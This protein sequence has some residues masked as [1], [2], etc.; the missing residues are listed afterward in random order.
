MSEKKVEIA[1]EEDARKKSYSGEAALQLLAEGEKVCVAVGKK[2]VE[3]DPAT[4]D[5]DLFLKK[6]V[7]PSGNLRAPT[8]R[9]GKVF[10]VGY[11]PEMYKTLL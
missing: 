9:V 5:R 7:G 2:V 6:V 1:V 8:V 11:H 3:F 10:Y 4:M